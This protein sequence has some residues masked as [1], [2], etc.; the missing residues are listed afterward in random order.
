M[1]RKPTPPELVAPMEAI[2]LFDFTL[3]SELYTVRKLYGTFVQ[4]ADADI[5]FSFWKALAFAYHTGRV[6][7]IREERKKVRA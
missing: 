2:K 7:G 5:D 1:S 6:Q 3:I 4:Q